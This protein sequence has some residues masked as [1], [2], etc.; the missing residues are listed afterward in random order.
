MR[1]IIRVFLHD[2]GIYELQYDTFRVDKKEAYRI[3]E[4]ILD[5]HKSEGCG[6]L[7]KTQEELLKD[8]LELL[9]S[10]EDGEKR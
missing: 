5:I 4:D 9:D 1:P 10:H 3:I 8:S 7:S 2:D 6:K